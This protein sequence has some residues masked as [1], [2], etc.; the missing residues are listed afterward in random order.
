MNMNVLNTLPIMNIMVNDFNLPLEI[1]NEII[2][3][4]NYEK[5]YKPEHNKNYTN[6]MG[7]IIDIGNIIAV[8]M[9]SIAMA[10]WG[11]DIKN[12]LQNNEEDYE[13]EEE[14]EWYDYEFDSEEE[15]NF[16][17]MEL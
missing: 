7:D 16:S 11:M 15:Y 3:F 2:D 4:N 14:P 6:V 13:Y 8:P 10:C 17:E 5:Y 9:P 1:A 12:V